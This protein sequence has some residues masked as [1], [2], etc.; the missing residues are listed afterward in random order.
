MEVIRKNAADDFQ[1]AV[2]EYND[3]KKLMLKI[4]AS[5]IAKAVLECEN[6]MAAEN[7]TA[8]MECRDEMEANQNVTAEDH[9]QALLECK[10]Q[11]EAMQKEAEDK[12]KVLDKERSA[13]ATRVANL[14]QILKKCNE[15]IASLEQSLLQKNLINSQECQIQQIDQHHERTNVKDTQHTAA[16]A[17]GGSTVIEFDFLFQKK[18]QHILAAMLQRLTSQERQIFGFLQCF[19]RPLP[20]SHTQMAELQQILNSL[21]Y[22]VEEFRANAFLRGVQSDLNLFKGWMSETGSVDRHWDLLYGLYRA[23]RERFRVWWDLNEKEV[24]NSIGIVTNTSLNDRVVESAEKPNIESQNIEL[25]QGNTDQ[26]LPDAQELG[27]ETL[28]KA[29]GMTDAVSTDHALKQQVAQFQAFIETTRADK[30]SERELPQS[31]HKPLQN[32]IQELQEGMM[33][34]EVIASRS[35]ARE[36]GDTAQLALSNAEEQLTEKDTCLKKVFEQKTHLSA[37]HTA[38]IK[39]RDQFEAE[40]LSKREESRILRASQPEDTNLRQALGKRRLCFEEREGEHCEQLQ[41]PIRQ[42]QIKQQ[43]NAN[44]HVALDGES[45]DCARTLH[46]SAEEKHN[47]QVTLE[48]KMPELERSLTSCGVLTGKPRLEESQETAWPLAGQIWK[49]ARAATNLL[50]RSKKA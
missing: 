29:D 43:E 19:H 42:S 26:T 6:Q 38:N 36:K 31:R 4:V 22:G 37:E 15:R 20:N 44:I 40:C 12:D 10:T 11:I 13:M 32:K 16:E 24:T 41:G 18:H 45:S 50:G 27:I 25:H 21:T 48:A 5:D 28:A 3:Q 49:S 33:V 17:A 8:L 35:T 34:S 47:L 2:L 1:K 30:E 39:G 7:E 46:T 14:E 9:E 23:L